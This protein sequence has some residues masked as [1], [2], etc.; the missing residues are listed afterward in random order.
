[1][2]YGKGGDGGCGWKDVSPAELVSLADGEVLARLGT[3]PAGLPA[4]EAGERERICGPNDITGVKRRHVVLRFL[5]H[6]GNVLVLVLLAAAAVLLFVG[7]LPSAAITVAIVVASVALDFSQ[8]YR[9]ETAAE[10]LRQK[11]LTHAT[12]LRDGAAREVPLYD[13][14]P[15]D[16]VLL[17]AGDIVPAD[18][19]VIAARDLFV[20]ESALTGEPF[21]VEKHA[22]PVPAGTPL[23]SAKNYVFLGTSVVSGTATAV[24]ARTG[25]S[26]EFGRIARTLVERPPETEFERGLA[27]FSLLMSRFIFL[28]VLFVFAVN[29]LFRHDT[30]GSFLFAVALAVGMPPE[31]LPMILSLNLSKGA[32][33]MAAKKVIVRHSAAIQNLGSMDVLCTD[34]TGT[35]TENR[36]ALVEY[37]GP[38]GEPCDEVL[39]F[40]FLNSAFSTGVKNP[41]DEAIVSFRPMD[42]GPF[43][44]VDEIPFDFARRRVSVLAGKGDERVLVTKGAP[45]A[46]LSICSSIARGGVT[47][48]ITDGDRASINALYAR[49]SGEGFRTLAVCRKDLPPGRNAASRDDE[50][51]MTFL[52]L[53]T[54]LDPPRA[55]AGESVR[56]LAGAGIGLKILTGDNEL[57]AGRIAALIG[58]PME[59]VLTG[60]EIAHMDDEALARAAEKTTLFCRVTPVQKTRIVGVLRKNGHVVGFMGD[61][62]NDASAIREA[63]V[64]I[65]VR[66]A[67]DIARESADIVLLEND[68]R[69]LHDGVLE[70]RKT[71]GNTLKYILMG[72]S[73]N[74]GNMVSV[75]GASLFLPFLPML[76]IQILLNNLLYDISES[77]IPTDRVDEEYV[78]RPKRWDI[79][80]IRRFILVFG[81]I[82]S[83]FDFLT[84]AILLSVFSAG[85]SFFQTAWFVE[86]LCTQTLIIFVIRT[87]RVPFFRSRPSAFLLASTLS[88]VAAACILPFSPA[89]GLFG[90]VQ[91]PPAFYPVLAALVGA[92]LLLAEVAKEWFY[93]K[94]LPRGALRGEGTPGRA[95]GN[96]PRSSPRGEK[97]GWRG[98][99]EDPWV[100]GR[101]GR[102]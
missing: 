18:A 1:M 33:A 26:T 79:G 10:L 8:E 88:A 86:S 4:A 78:R 53:V 80:F 49:K 40:A 73:S 100:C 57:V 47:R 55:T 43:R 69:V 60:E 70:G 82:S 56:A 66:E 9:A 85:E 83:L 27:A 39:S 29:A 65:S 94:Y 74:F 35:L 76:P 97:Q 61:G 2:G 11:I 19:R 17:S 89:A 87:E 48:P 77:T 15:G 92:Y 3:T 14:V 95:A 99:R 71:F 51:D 7:D 102:S 68:L 75:A 23:P 5:G 12:V 38:D 34:K 46:I 91:P 59:G 30:L 62:I 52:G 16:I 32:I 20:N 101:R 72:T 13:V 93:G 98:E 36:I 45:E 22:G 63:D 42:T 28:L 81:P 37:L 41:L 50:R 21:P 58:L 6:F 31:L 24:V 25:L 44:K 64:G 90:F 67:V 96:A 84:F 54:F